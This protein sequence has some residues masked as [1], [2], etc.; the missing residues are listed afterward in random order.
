MNRC[1]PLPPRAAGPQR[2]RSWRPTRGQVAAGLS[3]A[4]LALL[5][6]LFGAAASHFSLPPSDSLA[7]AFTGAEVWFGS[8]GHPG[9]DGGEADRGPLDVGRAE[10]TVD[11]PEATCDGFTLCT[12]TQAPEAL[13]LD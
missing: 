4:A 12:T 9:A 8:L 6:F 10:V 11:R 7:K 13:L 5:C 3:I 2:S 1:L